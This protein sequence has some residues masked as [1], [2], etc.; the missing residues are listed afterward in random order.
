METSHFSLLLDLPQRDPTERTGWNKLEIGHGAILVPALLG[1]GD[2][3]NK[4]IC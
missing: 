4:K 3:A 2:H 1:R